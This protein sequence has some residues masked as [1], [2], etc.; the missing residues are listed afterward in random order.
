MIEVLPYQDAQFGEV[1]GLWRTVFPED[2]PHSHAAVAVPQ[3]LATQRELF[4]VAVEHGRVLGTILAGYDGHRGWLYKLAVH[5]NARRCGIGEKLVRAAEKRLA[6][7]GCV[8][9]NLQVRDTNREAARFWAQMG[10]GEEPRISMGRSL[11]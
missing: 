9:V 10:Y 3:K 6:A 4:L 11:A 8:K 1:D 5:P 7:L 2:P